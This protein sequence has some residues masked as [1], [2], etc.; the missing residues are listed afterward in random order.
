MLACEAMLFCGQELFD[1]GCALN[2]FVD[3]SLG[4]SSASSFDVYGRV[5][6]QDVAS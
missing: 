1:G 2:E 5:G 3:E 4:A 6:V